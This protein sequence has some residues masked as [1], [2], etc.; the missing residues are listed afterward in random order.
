MSNKG[1]KAFDRTLAK[2]NLGLRRADLTTLQVNIGLRC[3]LTCR[4]CHL[5]ASPGRKELMSAETVAA[6]LDFA[7][8]FHFAVIDVT[9]GAPEMNSHVLELLDGLAPLTPRLLLRSNLVAMSGKRREDLAILCR[10][11]RVVIVASFPALNEAQT[12]AQRGRGVF[13]E[14]LDALRYLNSLAYGKPGSGLELDLVSNPS[15]AFVPTAQEA[16]E[17]RFREVLFQKWGIEFNHLYLFANVPLG[18]FEKWLRKNG[19]YVGYMSKLA[20]HFNPEALDGVMC[21]NLISVAWDGYLYDCDFNQA[22]GI[23]LGGVNAHISAL[24]R[25]PVA[26]D[27]VAVADHCYAC[28]AGAGFT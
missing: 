5:E 28:T 27:L 24:A 17:R 18:R 8:K 9:G 4:H 13:A 11:R 15:G 14:S 21:R 12:E 23:P 1:V 22:A 19:N 7:K 6:V 2:Y 10:D 26:G 20:Q 25:L 16:Q 3:N